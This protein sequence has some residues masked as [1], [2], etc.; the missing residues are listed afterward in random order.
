M[1]SIHT[2]ARAL[3]LALTLTAVFAVSESA[4]QRAVS[5]TIGPRTVSEI[6]R[7][8]TPATATV[9][10]LDTVGDTIAQGSGFFVGPGQKIRIFVT[11]FHVLA[12]ASR[13][14]IS[15]PGGQR[16]EATSVLG[17]DES[18]DLALLRAD[19]GEV[20]AVRLDLPE[21][22][23]RVVA[24]GTPLGLGHT[25]SE[26]I[27]S[28]HRTVGT[29]HLVQI[30]AP[31]SPGS[32]GGAVLDDRG[33]VFAVATSH[34]VGGQ[35]LN[36]AVPVKAGLRLIAQGLAPRTV[37]EVFARV[38]SH[39][40]AAPD[41]GAVPDGSC[42]A[43]GMATWNVGYALGYLRSAKV[44]AETPLR[45]RAVAELE[46]QLIALIETESVPNVRGAAWRVADAEHWELDARNSRRRQ[47]ERINRQYP[48][49]VEYALEKTFSREY[50]SAMELVAKHVDPRNA[51]RCAAG[52]WQAV[53]ALAIRAG[54]L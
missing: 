42:S 40:S 43:Q 16:F 12:G 30:T 28:A 49:I 34:L 26:G 54:A 25:V 51:R 11:N 35:Q 37:A 45:R 36:F 53:Q 6:A 4:A 39:E 14:L 9:L 7:L 50:E 31:I 47:E 15:T 24:I 23:E 3:V 41:S 33:R 46:T 18:I 32:S 38:P 2:T 27:V 29:A 5:D 1:N 22:G 21:V 19:T 8:A 52:R 48:T 10:A 17:A 20:L 44:W 13:A